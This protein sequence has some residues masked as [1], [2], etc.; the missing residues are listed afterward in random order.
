[1]ENGLSSEDVAKKLK[2]FGHNELPDIVSKNWL[3]L[4]SAIRSGRRI[5][6]NLQKAMSYVL[7]I[8]IPIIGMALIPS[9]IA[10]GFSA[11]IAGK[12]CST[13]VPSKSR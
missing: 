10:F 4:V 2:E 8:H 5:F 6:D 9:F 13:T 3:D 11:P 1:M 12:L 7:A